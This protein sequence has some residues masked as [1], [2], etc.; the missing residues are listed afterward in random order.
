VQVNATNHVVGTYDGANVR[1]YLNGALVATKAASGVALNTTAG[2]FT[3]RT[4]TTAQATID[5]VAVYP[6]ALSQTRIQAHY[7]ASFGSGTNQPPT[8][9]ITSPTNITTWRVGT[10]INFSGG[11]TDPE[12]GTLPPTALSW[13]I[14]LHHCPSNCHTHVLQTFD[15][16]ASGSFTAP[17]HEYPSYIEVRLTA[18]D[19]GNASDS[20]SVDLQP[21]TVTITLQSAPTGLQ[22]SLN[23]ETTAAPYTRTVIE[24]STNTV[25][26]PNQTLGGTP[27]TFANWSDSGAQSHNLVANTSQTLTATFTAGTPTE[28][29]PPVVL[30]DSPRLYWR[31]G[32]TADPFADSSGNGNS[33]TTSGSGV[34][35][36]QPDLVA[37]D[38][39]HCLSFTDGTT[40]VSRGSVSGLSSTQVTVEAWFRTGQFAN[41]IDLASHNWGGTGGAGWAIYTTSTRQLWWGLWESG[42][43]EISIKATN[44]AVN[45]T[46]HVVGTY[47]G[48][49]LRLYL[50]GVL[51]TSKTIGAKTLNTS[52]SVLTGRTDT[53][54]PVSVD[55]FA[56][57]P[58]ALSTAR[59]QAHYSAGT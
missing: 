30:A 54:S 33:A 34:S 20:D 15:D 37:G 14:I 18:T 17:D 4:D 13:S 8:A 44:L 39:D 12:D 58:T 45:T 16:V 22:L 43:S 32:E 41:Y 57:Y 27:Y 53:T 29:Y 48:N 3:G 35:R 5:E 28:P 2:L 19:S 59:V 36:G 24:G 42:S 9:T 52:A 23:A 46:Y 38:T 6:T 26:A 49:V 11:A 25:S 51:V 47:D 31:L 50:N 21:R 55:E 1:L 40:F 10:T 7:N 56:V